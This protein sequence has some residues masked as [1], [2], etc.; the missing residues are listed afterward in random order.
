[1][2]FLGETTSFKSLYLVPLP[3]FFLNNFT[4]ALKFT[5][6]WIYNSLN[7]SRSNGLLALQ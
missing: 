3:L 5:Q 1:M 7:I 4:E 2:I 6:L